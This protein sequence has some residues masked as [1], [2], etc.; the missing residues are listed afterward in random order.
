VQGDTATSTAAGLAAF[1]RKVAIGHVEA[2][3]RTGN[4]AS[5]WPGM[6]S[7]AVPSARRAARARAVGA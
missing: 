3:L 7:G 4:I 6:L 5:P 1:F 2:G